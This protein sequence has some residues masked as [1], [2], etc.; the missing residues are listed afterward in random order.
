MSYEMK[1][2]LVLLLIIL[3]E[4]G[5]TEACGSSCSWYCDCSSRV[6]NSVPQDLPTNITQLTLQSNYITTLSPFDFS[7]YS[8]LTHLYLNSN[9]ISTVNM[10]G[11]VF[12][13]LSRLT[14]L[15]LSSNQLTILR[16]DMFVGLDNLQELSLRFNN[17][18]SIEVGTF[19]ATPQLHELD[20]QHNDIST[21]AA[22]VFAN[23]PELQYID[24]SDNDINTFPVEALSNLRRFNTSSGIGVDMNRNQMKT[25]PSAAYDILASF[26]NINIR[27]NPW[28]CDCRMLPFKQKM[29]GSHSFESQITCAGPGNLA[30]QSLLTVNP[31]DLICVQTTTANVT[32]N[33][34]ANASG[35]SAN[36]TPPRGV[37]THSTPAGG[38]SAD[39]TTS[40][41]FSLASFLSGILGVVAGI[42][43][44]S[45]V[46][47]AIWYRS[48]RK[49]SLAPS[50]STAPDT[51]VT[52]WDPGP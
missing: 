1:R 10:Y 22:G 11:G 36:S 18:H 19:D 51:R 9:Q 12:Y 46:F 32:A 24:L 34:T 29:N 40:W 45:A 8:I 49:T 48:T 33:V 6:L 27:G 50:P 39:S 28:Q 2:F 5:P 31:E 43:L 17:I 14:R 15:W 47:L 44:A 37:P 30:G 26:P 42:L 21:I 20:L 16:A 7:R 13:S 4:A 25:L 41:A 3:K 38:S 35:V 52:A 23:L